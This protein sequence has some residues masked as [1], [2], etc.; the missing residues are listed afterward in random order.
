MTIPIF[1]GTLSAERCQHAEERL[2]RRL[3]AIILLAAFAVPSVGSGG[4][5]AENEAAVL[6]AQRFKA[7][8]IIGTG[9]LFGI[10]VDCDHE[11]LQALSDALGENESK[12]VE[13]DF[14]FVQHTRQKS[15]ARIEHSGLSPMVRQCIIDRYYK[16]VTFLASP[17]VPEE[18]SSLIRFPGLITV[19]K[20]PIV[21]A[22]PVGVITAE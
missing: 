17:W 7:G 1:A 9:H 19:G 10:V 6:F 13:Y 21:P 15:K 16:E 22:T 5:E 4:S 12:V 2:N 14:T 8:R 20:P 18:V 11:R 3:L